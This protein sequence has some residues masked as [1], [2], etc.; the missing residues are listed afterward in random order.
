MAGT[1]DDYV[2]IVSRPGLATDGTVHYEPGALPYWTQTS[3]NG[4]DCYVSLSEKNQI[5]V[6]DYRT[7]REVARI[8]VGDYPQRERGA[9]LTPEAIGSLDPSN[10]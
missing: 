5:S 1:I 3:P 6:I 8:D 2:S 4:H 9:K 7:A 10:G